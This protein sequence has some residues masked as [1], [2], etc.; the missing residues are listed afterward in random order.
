MNLKHAGM[1][2]Y[3][4]NTVRPEIITENS[5]RRNICECPECHG[6]VLVCRVPGCT[7]YAKS[8]T[9]YDDEL[10]PSCTGSIVSGVGEIVKY[11]FMAVAAAVGGA[12]IVLKAKDES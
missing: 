2:P 3:C 12:V 5:I 10:C 6:K 9:V 8:G 4:G 7:A 11:G 1:C